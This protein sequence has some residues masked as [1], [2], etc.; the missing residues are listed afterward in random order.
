M[1]TN[2]LLWLKVG[3][4]FGDG[5]NQLTLAYREMKKRS[6]LW[7]IVERFSRYG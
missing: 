1:K 6:F 3:D 2:A 4:T 5:A 7:L